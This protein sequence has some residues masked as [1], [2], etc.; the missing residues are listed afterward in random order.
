MSMSGSGVP[1][2]ALAVDNSPNND[3]AE[4]NQDILATTVAGVSWEDNTFI[5]IHIQKT[6]L[7]TSGLIINQQWTGGDRYERKEEGKK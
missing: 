7:I 4:L 1:L 6:L 5:C 3:N 2:Y